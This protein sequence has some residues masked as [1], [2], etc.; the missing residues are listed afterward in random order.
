MSSDS[1]KSNILIVDDDGLNAK[2]LAAKLASDSYCIS[3]AQSGEACLVSVAKEPPDLILLDVMMPGMDGY[4]VSRRIKSNPSSA[5]IPILFVTAMSDIGDKRRGFDTGAV[6]YITK[7]FDTHEIKARVATHLALKHARDVLKKQNELLDRQVQIRTAAL[8]E[9]NQKLRQEIDSKNKAYEELKASEAKTRAVVDAI[10]DE[11]WRIGS[12]SIIQS[13]KGGT[14]NLPFDPAGMVGQSIE[15]VLP[16]DAVN[17]ALS[18][19]NAALTNHSVNLFECGYPPENPTQFLEFRM[20]QIKADEVA[21]IIR[22]V[23]DHKRLE[24]ELRQQRESLQ[25]ENLRLKASIRERY[26]LGKIIG[27]SQA[28]QKVYDLI[29]EA[30]AH[31]ISV[32]LTGESGTGK[33]LVANAIHEVSARREGPFVPVNCGAI[34]ENLIESEFFGYRKGA[35]TGADADKPG[36][37]DL[38]DGGT[39][40][41]DE[42]GEISMG[43][44]VKLL[45]VIEGNGYLSIGGE[46]ARRHD[47][48]FVC[49]TNKDPSEMVKQG[50]MREDFFYRIH[51]INIQLPPLRDR[52]DDLPLLIE[53]FYNQFAQ[54]GDAPPP[55]TGHLYKSLLNYHW[56]GNV[57]ELQNTIHRY[58]SSGKVDFMG[59][60]IVDK[61]IDSDGSDHDSL[62]RIDDYKSAVQA[63]EKQYIIKVLEENQWHREKAAVRMGIPRRTFFRKLKTLGINVAP[64]VPIVA[65]WEK[66]M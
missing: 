36:Y 65:L 9:T 44:Q 18:A 24:A 14:A 58:V 33:E 57:R 34:P 42:I 54:G 35:F 20:V 8:S 66:L 40:L 16:A 64:I 62:F 48:R 3:V 45:R 41:L 7:P 43:M 53:H 26:R 29:M 31:D 13:R 23:T 22:D 47:V 17:A 59:E 37:L 1:L 49:A 38:A 21:A 60:S 32:V 46:Q 28:I 50:K 10:P 25:Q 4:E 12:N 55:I 63:F 56:P 39:L 61:V 52:M 2:L 30:G 15:D 27:K 6:D 5:E 19:L 11:V 51:V